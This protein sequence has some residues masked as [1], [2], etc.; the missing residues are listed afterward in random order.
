MQVTVVERTRGIL[1]INLLGI[2]QTHRTGEFIPSNTVSAPR[3]RVVA[4]GRQDTWEVH[5]RQ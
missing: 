2:G 5:D 3:K 4:E 1:R